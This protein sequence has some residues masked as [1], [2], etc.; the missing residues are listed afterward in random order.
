M[1]LPQV[2]TAEATP[3]DRPKKRKLSSVVDL[4]AESHARPSVAPSHE[5]S[6][7][8][9][10][11]SLDIEDEESNDDEDGDDGSLLED[12]VDLV[13]SEPYI[14]GTLITSL[15]SNPRD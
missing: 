9:N 2:L 4:A 7:N 11:A 8:K 15:D 1:A 6:E 5:L 14:S 13:D 3:I 10:E 12:I